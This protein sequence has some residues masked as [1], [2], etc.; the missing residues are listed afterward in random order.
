M[1]FLKPDGTWHIINE[2]GKHNKGGWEDS[3]ESDSGCWY[4][5]N[6][7]RFSPTIVVKPA[8]VTPRYFFRKTYNTAHVFFDSQHGDF[9]AFPESGMITSKSIAGIKQMIDNAL[10][11]G[12]DFSLKQERMF[13][14]S[15]KDACVVEGGKV[16]SKKN[17]T[18]CGYYKGVSY[19]WDENK[20]VYYITDTIGRVEQTSIKDI[21]ISIDEGLF[22]GSLVSDAAAAS[23]KISTP[24]PPTTKKYSGKLIAEYLGHP[25]FWSS[26]HQKFFFKYSDTTVIARK[27]IGVLKNSIEKKVKLD[28]YGDIPESLYREYV[29]RKDDVD[30]EMAETLPITPDITV[31]D[32]DEIEGDAVPDFIDYTKDADFTDEQLYNAA[33]ANIVQQANEH[34]PS[35]TEESLKAELEKIGSTNKNYDPEIPYGEAHGVSYWKDG[36]SFYVIDVNGARMEHYYVEGI[37]EL[38][39]RAR[40]NKMVLTDVETYSNSSSVKK[41]G[42]YNCTPI[43]YSILEKRYF[44]KI[45]NKNVYAKNLDVL[46]SS[47]DIN[48]CNG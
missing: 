35:N 22:D 40:L 7:W 21:K 9:V 45:N 29:N 18:E 26:Q 37:I 46:K 32:V 16:T 20:A 39:R 31:N 33:W 1:V 19:F 12:R 13:K 48:F 2:K 8:T 5:N 23:F 25:Y 17:Y 41:T 24:T 38:I 10:E 15:S 14:V 3:H 27:S 34:E 36:D 30:M 11:T 47:I 4:S 44:Y 28:N 42:Y 43:Y 6:S